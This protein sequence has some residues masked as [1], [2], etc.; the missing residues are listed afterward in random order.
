MSGS[1]HTLTPQNLIEHLDQGS[2]WPGPCGLS[3]DAAY[4]QALAVRHLR[5]ER[6]EQPFGYKI[7]FTNRTIWPLYQVFAPIWG[8]VWDSTL[9]HCDGDGALSLAHTCQPRLEPEIVFGMKA[10]PPPEASFEELFDAIDWMAPGFEVVQS[11]LPDWTFKAADTV[12]DSGLHARLLVGSRLPVR[13][14]A[15]DA[16]ELDSQLAQASMTLSRNGKVVEQGQ[17]HNV[18]NS[19]LRALHH[20]LGELRACPGAPDLQSG[21]VVTTG[22]WTDAWPM[23]PEQRWDA[24]FSLPGMTLALRTTT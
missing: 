19:P 20:F 2:L 9:Q 15:A 5:M 21:D 14:F 10:T 13:T 3:L 17:G 16:A 8:I 7:G 4:A 1:P 18:L 11:Q 24:T 23:E 22:T 6:G 12:A